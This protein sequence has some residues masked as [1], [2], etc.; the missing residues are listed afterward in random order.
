LPFETI[1]F[2]INEAVATITL[3]RPDAGNT[4]TLE[5][6]QE[7]NQAAN[8]CA[9]DPAIRAVVLTARGKMFC[10][11]GDLADFSSQGDNLGNYISQATTSLHFA[12]ARL[13]QMDA[14]VV[15][16]VNGMAAGGGLGVAMTGDIVIAGASA[17]FAV[18]YT[19]AGLSP[20]A[21]TTYMLP[22]LV[23]LRRAQELIFTNRRLSAEEAMQIGLVTEVV[24]DD[25]LQVRATELATGLAVGATKAFGITKR[26]LAS[27]FTSSM[28]TQMENE[29]RGIAASA[30]SRDGR[31]GMD[32]FLNKRK[33][34][35][36]GH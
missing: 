1:Q 33:P 19:A 28:E 6:A 5:F 12:I 20:D 23:G 30:P 29:A 2:D 21:S 4:V 15:T 7:F 18:A 11:G 24:A 14:P 10:A 3:N 35:F 16:A 31:E 9:T 17:K 25:E 8:L 32:A 26:L 13:H 22:R 36:K 27:S 34:E